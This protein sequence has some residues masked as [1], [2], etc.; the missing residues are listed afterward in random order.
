M[1]CTLAAEHQYLARARSRLF[2]ATSVS[3]P[4]PVGACSQDWSDCVGAQRI[5]HAAQPPSKYRRYQTAAAAQVHTSLPLLRIISECSTLRP[6]FV[7]HALP[8]NGTVYWRGESASQ[9]SSEV[10]GKDVQQ[11]PRPAASWAWYSFGTDG[12][13][14][15]QRSDVAA[16]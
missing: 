3:R 8:A 11:L 4:A 14:A 1:A 7:V 16:I 5:D 12:P 6:A 15:E 9:L 13:N 10:G 2:T